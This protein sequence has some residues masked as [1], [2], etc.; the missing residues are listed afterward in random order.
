MHI[1]EDGRDEMVVMSAETYQRFSQ[2]EL[3]ALLQ[4]GLEDERA[5]R[6]SPLEEAFDE[7]EQAIKN[8]T[9]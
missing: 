1:V 2:L 9:L 4:E 7:L 5:G 6:F 3:Y 8:G